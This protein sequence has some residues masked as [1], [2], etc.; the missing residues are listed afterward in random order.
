MGS[1][2]TL[3]AT[4]GRS[5]RLDDVVK[6][7]HV[8]RDELVPFGQQFDPDTYDLRVL[9]GADHGL[10]TT[11][12]QATI[13][14]GRGPRRHRHPHTEIIAVDDGSA[15]FEIGETTY[16]GAAGDMIVIPPGAWHRFVVTGD[17][18]LRN[19]AIHENSRPVTE[20]EDGERQD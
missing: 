11:V 8:R 1:N 2:P 13:A 9:S 5:I 17:R 4:L 14:P 3:S 16:D 15:R 19:T 7:R 12:M 20:W 18:P 10:V 6:P